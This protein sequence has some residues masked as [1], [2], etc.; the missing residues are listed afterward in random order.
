[1]VIT[2]GMPNK[3]SYHMI[4]PCVVASSLILT[5]SGIKNVNKLKVSKLDV[6]KKI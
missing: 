3:K 1:M 2:Y 4:L 6:N 5:T